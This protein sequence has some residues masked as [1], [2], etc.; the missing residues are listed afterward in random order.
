[1][2]QDVAE[3]V[4]ENGQLGLSPEARM[5]R[6]TVKARK[7]DTVASLAKRYKLAPSAVAEWNKVTAGAALA[8]GQVVVL[9]LPRSD[10]VLAKSQA[11]TGAKTA[12]RAKTS[13]SRP[14][15]KR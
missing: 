11:R 14:L 12:K 2:E 3:H 1:V 15:A 9:Y 6:A 13:K 4:A 10:K 5:R 8:S 7:G